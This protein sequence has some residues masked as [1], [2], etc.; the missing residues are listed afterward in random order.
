[1]SLNVSIITRSDETERELAIAE[2]HAFPSNRINYTRVNYVEK[3]K[4]DVACSIRYLDLRK[5]GVGW[6]R[7][8]RTITAHLRNTSPSRTNSPGP[9][10]RYKYRRVGK[11]FNDIPAD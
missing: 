5:K 11:P 6:E 9:S 7:R 1:M 3:V 2:E 8:K 4:L 10:S